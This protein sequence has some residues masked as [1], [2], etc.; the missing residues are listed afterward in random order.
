M[1]EGEAERHS[2]SEDL[3]S[4]HGV[5]AG[6]RGL[7]S[8]HDAVIEGGGRDQAVIWEVRERPR[9]KRPEAPAWARAQ[10]RSF[11]KKPNRPS[12]LFLMIREIPIFASCF[13]HEGR[14][15]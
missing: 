10:T 7:L 4:A 12:A 8:C 5:E 2:P 1:K 15:P 14:D 9:V 3:R 11:S 13:A 6:D